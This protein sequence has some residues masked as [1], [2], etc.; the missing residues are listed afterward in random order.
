MELPSRKNLSGIFFLF[1]TLASLFFSSMAWAVEKSF[2]VGNPVTAP[3][4][5]MKISF[6]I[7]A[8]LTIAFALATITRRRPLVAALCLVGTLVCTAGLY[9]LLHASFLAA[10]QVLV[11]AGAIMVLFIFV[12]MSVEKPE[13]EEHHWLQTP[14]AKLL[15]LAGI[16]LLGLRLLY[17]FFNSAMPR[18]VPVPDHFGQ[19]E[20]VGRLLFSE[21]LFPFEAISLLLLTAIIGAVVIT[22]RPDNR[23]A[24]N[25]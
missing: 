22:R 15:S 4:L 10:M 5:A 20:T 7:F 23:P 14:I 6:W 19:L 1:S 21:Y 16:V 17:V 12:I 18:W 9:L 2:T 25:D 8:G 13:Q 11:Y 3:T 24:D